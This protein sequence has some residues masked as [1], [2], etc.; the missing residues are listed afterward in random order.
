MPVHRFGFGI[1]L[2]TRLSDRAVYG[3][4]LNGAY[5]DLLDNPQVLGLCWI[6]K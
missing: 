6:Y 4:Q 2:D 1:G 5:Q 3:I